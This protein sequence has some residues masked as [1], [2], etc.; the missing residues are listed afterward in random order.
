[1]KSKTIIDTKVYECWTNYYLSYKTK[2]IIQIHCI[3]WS[4]IIIHINNRNGYIHR[5]SYNVETDWRTG[6]RYDTEYVYINTKGEARRRDRVGLALKYTVDRMNH[7]K[8]SRILFSASPL[9]VDRINISSWKRL[10]GPNVDW[11]VKKWTHE[12]YL[13]WTF[14]FHSGFCWN[15]ILVLR[16]RSM[17]ISVCVGYSWLV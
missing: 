6:K 7:L 16:G 10:I 11:K 9:E 1:M 17:E 2:T 8:S 12:R 3:I 13:V 14:A 4:R 5:Q 15:F